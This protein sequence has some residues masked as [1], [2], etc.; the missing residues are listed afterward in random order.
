MPYLKFNFSYSFPLQF[1]AHELRRNTAVGWRRADFSP[2]AP[3]TGLCSPSFLHPAEGK[4][5]SC[6]SSPV[7]PPLLCSSGQPRA[8][9]PSDCSGKIVRDCSGL[10]ADK[11][12]LSSSFFPSSL[13]CILPFLLA[14]STIF[15]SLLQWYP[16]WYWHD[17]IFKVFNYFSASLKW[18]D[19]FCTFFV[20][21]VCLLLFWKTSSSSF[22]PLWITSPGVLKADYLEK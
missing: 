4:Q 9:N 16:N 7:L 2:G 1:P 15:Y 11:I 8:A 22:G 19:T 5:E 14:S 20:F 21:C 3:S 12:T 18:L 10:S 17:F 13:G 6:E